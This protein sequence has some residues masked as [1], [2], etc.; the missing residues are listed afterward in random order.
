MSR[1]LPINFFMSVTDDWFDTDIY[2]FPIYK[3]S[4]TNRDV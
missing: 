3:I 1:L 2:A 4:S